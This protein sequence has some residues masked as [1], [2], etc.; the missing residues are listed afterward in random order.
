MTKL[1]A[2]GA[3]RREAAGE[4]EQLAKSGQQTPLAD[5]FTKFESDTAGLLV[6]LEGYMA[7]AEK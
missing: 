5:S 1:G 2:R 3:L 6:E 4:M 7:G